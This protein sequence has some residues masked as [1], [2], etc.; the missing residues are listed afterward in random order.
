MVKMVDQAVEQDIVFQVVHQ[1][2]VQAILPLHH[3]LK[4][5]LVVK[6]LVQIQV[7]AVVAELAHQVELAH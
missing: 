4:G 7:W 6:I 2:Q 3:H 5:H 1:E